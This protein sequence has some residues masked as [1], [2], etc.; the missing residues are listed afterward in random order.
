[1]C[2]SLRVP[3]S[4][5]QNLRRKRV[6]K[7]VYTVSNTFYTRGISCKRKTIRHIFIILHSDKNLETPKDLK[8]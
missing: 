8:H 1:M 5:A 3:V 7:F 2:V 4:E 6:F